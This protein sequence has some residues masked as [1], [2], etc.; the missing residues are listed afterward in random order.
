MSDNY[1]PVVFENSEGTEI[2]N[3]PVWHARKTLEQYNALPPQLQSAAGN[4]ARDDDG[5]DLEGDDEDRI[6]D[7]KSFDGAALKKLAKQRSLDTT[8]LKTVGDLR[9]RFI[10]LD[11]AERAQA[12][13]EKANDGAD[14]GKTGA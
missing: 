5:D 11:A 1:E 7:Y 12:E 2:S 13:V 14:S 6:E 8:G 10:E 3:D 4:A 9:A